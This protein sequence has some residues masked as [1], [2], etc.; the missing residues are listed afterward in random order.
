VSSVVPMPLAHVAPQLRCPV[1]S[2]PLES[3]S[4]TLHCG[5]GHSFD[6]ARQGY[7]A[8]T[9][10]RRRPPTGDDAAMVAARA[11]VLEAEHFAPLT[12]ALVRIALD[13]AAEDARVVLDVGA[14]TGHHLAAVLDALPDAGGVAV[15]A[16]KAALRRAAV[17]HPRIAAVAG[18]VWCQLPLR[19]AT[20]DLALDVFAPRNPSELARVLRPA[21]TLAVVTPAPDHLVELAPLRQVEVDPR[22]RER[23]YG[24]LGGL[25]ELAWARRVSW[26]LRLT[27]AEA[28]AVVRMGPA[29]R[30][31]TP[32]IEQR[33]RALPRMLSVTAAVDVH[34]FR[35]V[36]RALR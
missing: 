32:A 35:L 11:A 36:H 29:A 2:G 24:K 9:P 14:G 17:A 16:S 27:R 19:D 5:R 4:R 22:K 28:G 10:P 3:A 21:G 31:L 7:V 23:L 15:D 34:V 1:C 12:A 26:Q 6:V 33:F 20:V 13:T 30:H 18:D 8:L 25:F